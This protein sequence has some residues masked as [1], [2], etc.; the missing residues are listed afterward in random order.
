MLQKVASLAGQY[1]AQCNNTCTILF[2]TFLLDNIGF[3]FHLFQI[4]PLVL[5]TLGHRSKKNEQL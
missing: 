2:V 1:D 3:C 5:S 4:S